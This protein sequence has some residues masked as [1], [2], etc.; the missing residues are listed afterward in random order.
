MKIHPEHDPIP[1]SYELASI[2][3]LDRPPRGWTA[4]QLFLW[5]E[6]FANLL[7]ELRCKGEEALTEEHRQYLIHTLD[8]SLAAFDDLELSRCALD[9]VREYV[10][11]HVQGTDNRTAAERALEKL[12]LYSPRMQAYLEALNHSHWDLYE[13][14]SVTSGAFELR[15]LHDDAICWLQAP[16]MNQPFFIGHVVALRLIEVHD[17]TTAPL[18][19]QFDQGRLSELVS[20]LET[21]F[22]AG[23]WRTQEWKDFMIYRGSFLILRHA[24][25]DLLNFDRVDEE[26]FAEEGDALHLPAALYVAMEDAF[27][28]LEHALYR[29]GF[30]EHHGAATSP[31]VRKTPTGQIVRV[32]E[33][34]QCPVLLVFPD[35]SAHRSYERYIAGDLVSEVVD[36]ISFLR[37]WRVPAG[38]LPDDELDEL[39]AQ[40][41]EL[42]PF[43][44]ALPTRVDPGLIFEDVTPANARTLTEACRLIAQMLGRAK[45]AA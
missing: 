36:T 10:A 20:A 42:H 21:E 15:R 38:L 24:L 31:L 43:G 13:V 4:D 5:T 23:A 27:A 41:L 12:P 9:L 3:Q 28:L 8:F 35:E 25:A 6:E 39:A 19:M 7:E 1:H 16:E 32:E 26:D 11:L 30:N 37:L 29:E 40:G 17:V 33:G 18:A 22:A 2:A 14:V 44:L 45:K 34:G